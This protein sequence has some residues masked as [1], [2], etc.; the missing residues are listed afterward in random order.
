M[1][2][3]SLTRE[4]YTA[5][6]KFMEMFYATH[7]YGQAIGIQDIP[8]PANVSGSR[9]PGFDVRAY[10]K[11]RFGKDTVLDTSKPAPTLKELELQMSLN[12]QGVSD[13]GIDDDP[14]ET[15]VGPQ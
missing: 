10:C 9:F 6:D 5:F 13:P 7:P 1:S 4:Q 12:S 8:T 2:A 3:K 14:N 11:Q 15:N